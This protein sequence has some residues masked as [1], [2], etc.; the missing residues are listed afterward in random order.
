[1]CV[2]LP[3]LL[4]RCAT[5][6]MEIGVQR[7]RQCHVALGMQQYTPNSV[8]EFGLNAT[9]LN[10]VG[11]TA[12]VRHERRRSEQ[13]LDRRRRSNARDSSTVVIGANIMQR[14]GIVAEA[15]LPRCRCMLR[16]GFHKFCTVQGILA[17]FS[18]IEPQAFPTHPQP[19]VEG[20][21]SILELVRMAGEEQKG[22]NNSVAIISARHHAGL[23]VPSN[24]IERLRHPPPSGV[25]CLAMHV[26]ARAMPVRDNSL[27]RRS[28]PGLL[29]PLVH[30]SVLQ[31]RTHELSIHP[32]TTPRLWSVQ[33][34]AHRSHVC[35]GSLCVTLIRLSAL[36]AACLLLAFRSGYKLLF[37]ESNDTLHRR[38]R[39][40]VSSRF[41]Q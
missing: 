7:S 2:Y 41:L 15:L 3:H 40:V 9:F 29:L 31:Y 12:K 6:T 37:V 27:P 4:E 32:Q 8:P 14:E 11:L 26:S 19:H 36:G 25:V 23:L 35:H 18:A 38:R 34:H 10:T 16:V 17:H 33:N 24:I 21:A 22:R 28:L 39:P 13:H 5:A 1:M 30:H 20:G